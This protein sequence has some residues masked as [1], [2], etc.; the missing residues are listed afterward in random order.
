MKTLYTLDKTNEYFLDY[1][2]KTPPVVV[3]HIH[4]CI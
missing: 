4:G 3:L 1:N 2:P